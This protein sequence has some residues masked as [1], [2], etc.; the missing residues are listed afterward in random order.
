MRIVVAPDKFKGSL[1]AAAACAAIAR[2]VRRVCP[3]ADIDGCPMA[4]GGEGTLETLTGAGGG[5]SIDYEVTGPLPG[6]RVKAPI[7]LSADGSTAVV[8]LATAAGLRLLSHDQYDP[9][10]TTTYG[11]GELLRHAAAL[12]VRR[13]I[14]AVG[15]SATCD[16]GIGIVQAWGGV[17]RLTNG[18]TY[19]AGERKLTGSDVGLVASVARA[20]PY[21]ALTPPRLRPGAVRQLAGVTGPLLDTE[22]IDFIVASDVANPLYG[23]TGAA[24]VFAPQKGATPEQV[25]QF[26]GDLRKLCDR[27]GLHGYAA[28]PGA[29]A[30]G[31]AAFAMLAFF[32]ASLRNGLDVVAEAVRLDERL[33]TADLCFTGEGRFDT[34]SLA[35]KATIGVAAHCRSAGVPCVVLTGSVGPGMEDLHEEGVTAALSINSQ[36]MPRADSIEHAATLLTTAAEQAT[37]LFVSRKR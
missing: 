31:G 16:A 14:L 12:G 4:D 7:G 35:G 11:V 28:L 26:D 27:L 1:T 8:E 29:G 10:R 37:R 23:P 36:D 30:A 3:D 17:L 18:R 15:G 20:G 19:S 25:D 32:N 5:Q 2:G 13:V 22:G 6:M 33:K 24:A 34:Q 9:G 21:L